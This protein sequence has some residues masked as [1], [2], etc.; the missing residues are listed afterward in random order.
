MYRKIGISTKLIFLAMPP[1]H[2]MVDFNVN[3]GIKTRGRRGGEGGE[4][5]LRFCPKP[6]LPGYVTADNY[7]GQIDEN[8]LYLS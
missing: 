4:E 2:D 6:Q 1:Q 8:Y 5:T 3:Y 7:S